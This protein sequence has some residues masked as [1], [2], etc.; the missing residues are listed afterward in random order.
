MVVEEADVCVSEVVRG[1]VVEVGAHKK[2]DPSRLA[3]G[4]PREALDGMNL[5]PVQQGPIAQDEPTSARRLDRQNCDVLHSGAHQALL[6]AVR[7]H[8][9]FVVQNTHVF[10]ITEHAPF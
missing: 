8:V 1:V 5:E 2:R 3:F 6:D 10:N 7:Q 4:C 9:T